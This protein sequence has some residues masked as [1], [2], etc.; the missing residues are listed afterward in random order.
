MLSNARKNVYIIFHKEKQNG[1]KDSERKCE[2]RNV[3]WQTN[4]AENKWLRV[5]YFIFECG[6]F[7]KC[8][9]K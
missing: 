1:I 4:K 5:V 3:M 7:V 2:H 6:T 9:I 8:S